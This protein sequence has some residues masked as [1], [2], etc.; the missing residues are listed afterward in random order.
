QSAIDYGAARID[1]SGPDGNGLGQLL[2]T[3]YH[4]RKDPA[5]AHPAGF[6]WYDDLI[7]STQ[8]IAMGGG[9][10]DH[11]TVNNSPPPDTTRP[12][13]SVTSPAK[14]A[15][16]SGTITVSAAGSDNVGVV[17]VQFSLDGNPLGAEV[18]AAPYGVSWNTPT[19]GNGIH[20]LTA[21][22]RDAA[23]NAA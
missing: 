15:P 6:T 14:G 20:T 5:R 2:L 3:P 16:V 21:T 13:V 8:P 17:G 7:V 1:W 23:G 18:K 10:N 19:A 11:E 12:T 22:A 9:S 4:T